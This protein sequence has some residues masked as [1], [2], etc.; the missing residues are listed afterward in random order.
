MYSTEWSVVGHV[1]VQFRAQG[2]Y[3]PMYMFQN[4][5]DCLAPAILAPSLGSW[6]HMAW[7]CMARAAGWWG[8]PR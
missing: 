4:I 7:H 1:R 8:I 6:S 2:R 5:L 3:L